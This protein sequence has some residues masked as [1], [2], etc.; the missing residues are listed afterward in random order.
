M[1]DRKVFRTWLQANNVL[2]RRIDYNSGHLPADQRSMGFPVGGKFQNQTADQILT[3]ALVKPNSWLKTDPAESDAERTQ[4]LIEGWMK[5]IAV[6]DE[7]SML[8]YLREYFLG[9]GLSASETEGLIAYVGTLQNL[10]SRLFLSFIHSFV[11]TFYISS[12]ASY[13]EIAGGNW[14]LPQKLAEGRT[15]EIVMDARAIEIQWSDPALDVGGSKAIHRGRPG[16]YVRTLNEPA[17]KRGLQR[18]NRGRIECEFTADYLIVSIPFSA[19]RFVDVQLAFSFHK[20]RAIQELHYDSATKVLLEFRERF[21]EWDEAEWSRRLP[22]EYRGH[23]SV[24]GG[25]ITDGPNRFIY[26]PSHRVPGS[27]GGGCWQVIRG[28]TRPTD[29]TPYRLRIA[30]TMRLKG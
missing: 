7:Y 5:V 9:L 15:E 4:K 19:L 3:A 8:T 29:G 21:W 17:T 12:T 2:A 23:G 14:Q 20:R 18:S 30:I 26:Y 24:G 27:P 25:S 6:F 16:V 1:I 13:V 28:P 22:D 10:T 11:D